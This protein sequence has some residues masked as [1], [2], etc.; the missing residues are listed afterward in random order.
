MKSTLTVLLMMLTLAL[1]ACYPGRHRQ[2][3]QQ[4]ADLQACNQADSLLTDLPL[5]QS[6]AEWFDG[7]GTANEQLLAHYLL[8]RTHADRGE[9]P[10]AIAAYHD[11]VERA[12]TTATD[13]QYRTL[14]SVYAQMAWLYHQ[15]LLLSY[16]I[17]AHRKASH[18]DYLAKDTLY[19][20]FEKKMIAGIYIL[21]NKRDSAE[22]LLNGVIRLYREK[23]YEQEAL[24]TS[25]ML[26]S[27][28]SRS[29]KRQTALKQL[30]D[31]Y[32]ANSESFDDKHELPP[33]KRQ[34]YRYKG[35]Y[36][37]NNGDLDSA[38]Y[39]YRKI[40]R[41]NMSY[42]DMDP[43]YSGLL[44]VF[45]KKKVADS[46][47]KYARL[48]GAANDS[49]IA[50]KDRELT[51]RMSAS[52]QYGLYQKKALESEEKARSRGNALWCLTIA[53]FLLMAA[54]VYGA[55]YY[56][57]IQRRRRE[58]LVRIHEEEE[59][60]IRE[61]LKRQQRLSLKKEK[62]LLQIHQ[63]EK[64]ELEATYLQ[65]KS[66][67]EAEHLQKMQDMQDSYQRQKEEM[68]AAQQEERAQWVRQQNGI[69]VTW[70][71]KSKAFSDKA[72]CKKVARVA[73]TPGEKMTENDWKLL[74]TVFSEH[75][76]VLYKDLCLINGKKRTL[77]MRIAILTAMGFSNRKQT[78]LLDETKQSITNNMTALNDTLFGEKTATTFH[79]NLVQKYNI[80]I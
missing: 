52:Y 8:G 72:I 31:D 46:I 64:N 3:Q 2:M 29:P 49:S 7:H 59:A 23:D 61:E 1:A 63:Q 50:L 6:L 56:R 80:C 58:E 45:T 13:C 74:A 70:V 39:Y 75:F 17:E 79:A 26:M 14:A 77:R 24:L 9:A 71:D 38:E 33:S 60:R 10:A 18:Y 55:N 76:P 42:V 12:D 34:Y 47:A 36:Y 19:A 48:Y 32:E 66:K 4:L 57:K 53:V 40:Y 21:Q 67:I 20:I 22:T 11:A 43:L 62:D 68:E 54:S 25:T 15:Q 27:L 5:A 16:E 44:S 65:E 30:I 78:M 69:A 37:E 28:Y 35:L 73:A 41:P 51:A